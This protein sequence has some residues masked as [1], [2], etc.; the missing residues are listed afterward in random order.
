MHLVSLLLASQLAGPAAPVERATE[1]VDRKPRFKGSSEEGTRAR[2]AF[3][4]DFRLREDI[5]LDQW[6]S[7]FVTVVD[8]PS[9]LRA[10]AHPLFQ[11]VTEDGPRGCV[12]AIEAT[13]R[14]DNDDV[15]IDWSKVT[16][17]V[18]GVARGA[19][20]GFA[21]KVTDSLAQRP[22]T[23][24]PG[25]AISEQVFSDL[26]SNAD[27]AEGACISDGSN[28]TLDMPLRVGGRDDR[29][30]FSV[31]KE[32]IPATEAELFAFVE[33][34]AVSTPVN[35][36]QPVEVPFPIG[37]TVG[38]A[39]GVVA[40]VGVGVLLASQ[41]LQPDGPTAYRTP[42]GH[43]AASIILAA[44]VGLPV[45]ALA[46]GA[47]WWLFDA[48]AEKAYR[49]RLIGTAELARVQAWKDRRTA[50]GLPATHSAP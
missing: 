40:A 17:V 24:P 38:A 5:H 29:L 23:A 12:V 30:R 48:P 33:E 43:L 32:F 1:E 31:R 6:D 13:V 21:K 9:D 50:L 36:S 44:I 27:N 19:I 26:A 2:E 28:V 11:R 49:D 34:P 3:D 22:S 20:P 45:A 35:E 8:R 4:T 47:G 42:A 7:A 37:G 39:T 46:G 14:S 16:L 15:V 18:N 25:A 10:T 41:P